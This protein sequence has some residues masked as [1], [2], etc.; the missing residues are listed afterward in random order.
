MLHHF[1]DRSGLGKKLK[2]VVMPPMNDAV[3]RIE[4]F[5]KPFATFDDTFL[6]EGDIKIGFLLTHF[7]EGVFKVIET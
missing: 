2:H 6:V 1:V 7:D 4:H 5:D 3:V